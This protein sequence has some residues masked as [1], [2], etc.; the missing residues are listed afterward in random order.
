MTQSAR[1]FGQL[2][3]VEVQDRVTRGERLRIIDVREP[4]EHRIARIEGAELIPLGELAAR[5]GELGPDEEL[6]MVCHHG[7]RSASACEYLFQRGFTRI[8]NMS[9]GID[10]WSVEVD[11][12]V[13]R[14]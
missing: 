4:L 12:T 9:G 6:V 13:P 1:R 8:W 11:P 7:I 14:Y 3:P 2:L 5:V 10:R